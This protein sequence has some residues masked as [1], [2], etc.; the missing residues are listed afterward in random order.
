[1]QVAV[2]LSDLWGDDQDALGLRCDFDEAVSYWLQANRDT[3]IVE[4]SPSRVADT[5]ERWKDKSMVTVCDL[6][7][8]DWR[9]P[10]I[11]RVSVDLAMASPRAVSDLDRSLRAVGFRRSGRAWGEA[12]RSR[13]YV[14][15]RDP[16]KAASAMVADA[17][18]R[19]GAIWVR[20]RDSWLHPARR[21]AWKTRIVV[22]VSPDLDPRDVL[23]AR[24]GLPLPPPVI[25]NVNDLLPPLPAADKPPWRASFVDENDPTDVANEC[26]DRHGIRPISFSYPGTTWDMKGAP[27]D[28]IAPIIPGLPYSFT[29]EREYMATYNNAFLGLTHRKAGWDCFR[30]V[31]I[32]AAGALPLMPDIGQV[33]KFSMVHYPKSGM[34]AVVRETTESGSPPDLSTRQSLHDHFTQHL[35]SRAMAEY[36]MTSS[37]LSGA[38]SV[39]FVDAALPS[40]ADYLSVLTLIGLKQVFGRECALAYPADYIYSDS[41]TQTENLYGRGFGYTRILDG[42]LRSPAESTGRMPDLAHFDAVIIGS[43]SRNHAEAVSML[44]KFP[45][46]RTIWIL[47]EDTPPTV[48]E[49]H[50]L[51]AA[52]VQ[53]FVRAIHVG[54]R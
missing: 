40:A 19:I 29:D 32:L 28:L 54:G 53:P 44:K 3:L 33:P 35:T 37:G 18:V 8:V 36:V 39:L 1:M 41:R 26:F 20:F 7:S 21:L 22:R 38:S 46:S 23:D 45:A 12:G 10:S 50:T 42:H 16:S 14:R 25:I 17:K 34:A 6:A 43:V 15:T 2:H 47:G 27:R 24:Y 9:N 51:K 5:S 30:H 49:T 11:V 48:H 13:L 31:E 4:L 52:G